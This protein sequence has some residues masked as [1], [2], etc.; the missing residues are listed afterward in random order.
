MLA[1]INAHILTITGGEIE[2]GV[3][4]I[5]DGKIVQVGEHVD[6]PETADILDVE[7]AYLTPGLIDAHAAIGLK[8]E[9]LR[10]EGDDRNENTR[11]PITPHLHALDG[12][13][14]EDMGIYDAQE[15]GVTTVMSAPGTANVIGGQA[16]IFKMLERATA[17]E[18]FVETAGMQAALGEDPKGAWRAAK[19]MPSTRMGTAAILREALAKAKE[20]QK[21]L[22]KAKENPDKAPERDLQNEALVKVLNGDLPLIVHAHRAD[23]MMTAVRVAKEFGVKLILTTATEAHKIGDALKEADVPVIVGPISQ[24]RMKVETAARTITTPAQLSEAGVKFALT[25]NHPDCPIAS[26]P[27]QAGL[28]VRGGLC[29]EEAMK[30]IT[31]YP[32]EIL[33]MADRVGSIEAGKEADLVIWDGHPLRVY[34]TVLATF[35]GGELVYEVGYECDCDDDDCDCHDHDHGDDCDCGCHK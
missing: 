31:I 15:N 25:T 34:S 6:I 30:A 12:F 14:P 21:K 18:L 11:S 4:L 32:A 20:Y 33:G 10:W 27:M 16:G 28:A 26:L 1:I 5:E 3:V 17:D 29:P 9:G 35:V 19:K 23:D 8:E 13:N 22:E 24:A 2:N 7:G